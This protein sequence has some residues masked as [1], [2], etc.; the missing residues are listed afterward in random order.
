MHSSLCIVCNIV[1][2]LH[3]CRSTIHSYPVKLVVVLSKLLLDRRT[4]AK[5]ERDR[6]QSKSNGQSASKEAH[7][8][9]ITYTCLHIL[10][11]FFTKM[12]M[13]TITILDKH[14]T[15]PNESSNAQAYFTYC[16]TFALELIRQ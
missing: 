15:A 9:S 7:W 13:H 8:H 4:E 5:T 12:Q 16:R 14:M 2:Q 3:L 10:L 6:E 1:A 11:M